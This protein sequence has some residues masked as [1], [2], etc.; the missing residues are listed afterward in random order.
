M[1]PFAFHSGDAS[2]CTTVLVGREAS[3]DGSIMVA[4]A[5][6][7]FSFMPSLLLMNPAAP[8]RKY[9]GSDD[10]GEAAFEYV[11]PAD[12]MRYSS[13]PDPDTM[14]FGCAGFN[15]AGLAL[16]ATE[17]I[18]ANEAVLALDPYEKL[19]IAERDIADV[20]LSTAK[21]AREGAALLGRLI[22]AHGAGEG[23]GVAF[24]DAKEVWYL[25]TGSGHQWL[26]QRLPKDQYFA[27]GNQGRL[28]DYDPASPDFMASATVVFWAEANGFYNRKRDGAFNFTRVYA[29]DDERDETYSYPRVWQIQKILTPALRQ[30]VSEA[31][32]FPV[33][34]APAEKISLADLEAVMRNHYE[35]GELSSHDP[36]TKGLRGDEPFRPV[37]VFRTQNTHILQVRPELPQAIGRVNWFALGMADLSVF[38]PF[39]Q[40]LD[41]FPRAW[42]IGTDEAD[43][44]SAFWKIRKLQ[45]L[46]M[47]DYPALAPIVKD[48]FAKFEAETR[49]KCA[50][51]EAKYLKLAAQD[52]GAAAKLLHDFNFRVADDALALTARLTNRVFTL[53]TR[54]I[55]AEV[56]F[57]NR[58]S[59]D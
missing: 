37:T 19:G 32:D 7:S 27:S 3:T 8:G 47:T 43:D 29:R 41:A 9:R 56:P 57:K 21:T 28:K 33:F 18:Y 24:A 4:R 59:N 20:I 31:P 53:R 34:A 48:A 55:E 50:A 49:G 23:F 36:Y 42:G 15:S 46:V 5:V 51:F 58:S 12:A 17:T 38:V 39:Y 35:A 13:A 10:P 40:G 45:T 6:D 2:S 26:A 52:P 44:E 25:E 16:S 22:E 14:R 30:E 54:S 1:L 11:F